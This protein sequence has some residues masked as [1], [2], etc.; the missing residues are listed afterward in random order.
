MFNIIEPQF[1]HRE[2]QNIIEDT[3]KKRMRKNFV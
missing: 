3:E 1:N 2:T